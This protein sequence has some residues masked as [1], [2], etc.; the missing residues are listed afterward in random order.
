MPAQLRLTLDEEDP[1]ADVGQSDGG[2]HAGHSAT[3][4]Q[5]FLGG[6]DDDRLE[7]LR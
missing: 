2:T 1:E 6:L 4:Y 5:R 3:N 7:R